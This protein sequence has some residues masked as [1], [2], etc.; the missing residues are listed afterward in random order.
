MRMWYSNPFKKTKI[1][2]NKIATYYNKGQAEWINPVGQSFDT[3]GQT[4]QGW[5]FDNQDYVENE[6]NIFSEI[7][8]EL[9]EEQDEY[10][11]QE[12]KRIEEI[13]SDPDIGDEDQEYINRL[14]RDLEIYQNELGDV[15]MSQM[16]VSELVSKL[17]RKG[18]IRKVKKAGKI[19]YEFYGDESIPIIQDDIYKYLESLAHMNL[20]EIPIVLE[21][22]QNWARY[23]F[24]INDFLDS[25]STLLD[26]IESGDN[27]ILYDHG[28]LNR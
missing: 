6:T 2:L 7:M 5:I 25:G 13:L 3:E 9:R 27:H 12:I 1:R 19:Y 14:N 24:K 17:I 20:P 4:H 8:D 28:L 15:D 11:N 26:W 22:L 16:S 21:D 10:R 23:S 18:W